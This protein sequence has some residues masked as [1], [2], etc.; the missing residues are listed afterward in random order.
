MIYMVAMCAGVALQ[1]FW[2]V[3]IIQKAIKAV[4]PVSEELKKD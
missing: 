1:M 4:S 3:K 2:G